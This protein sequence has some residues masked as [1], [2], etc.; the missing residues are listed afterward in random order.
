M[1]KDTRLCRYMT[2]IVTNIDNT[3]VVLANLI[4][5]I[6]YIN[7]INFQDKFGLSV[8]FCDEVK[9]TIILGH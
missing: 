4:Q 5:L 6:K 1:G 3:F 7:W 9:E 2:N 8:C